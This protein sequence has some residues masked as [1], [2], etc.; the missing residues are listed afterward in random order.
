MAKRRTFEEDTADAL[1][2]DCPECG[3]KAGETCVA[4]VAGMS[5]TY[6]HMKRYRLADSY[7]E[8]RAIET[9]K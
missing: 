1:N 2:V 9:R 6:P 7:R 5:R 4:A 3:R 8:I